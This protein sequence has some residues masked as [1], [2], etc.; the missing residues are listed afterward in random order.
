[1]ILPL[2]SFSQQTF[3]EQLSCAYVNKTNLRKNLPSGYREGLQAE[4][5]M[6]QGL[7]KGRWTLETPVHALG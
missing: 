7:L 1:M 6:L 3:I 4:A 2:W 5:L